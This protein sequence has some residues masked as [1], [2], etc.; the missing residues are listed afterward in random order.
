MADATTTSNKIRN[1][2]Y[3]GLNCCIE[4]LEEL[5]TAWS[6]ST[7]NLIALAN[8]AHAWGLDIAAFKKPRY[9]DVIRHRQDCCFKGTTSKDAFEE[10]TFSAVA[11]DGFTTWASDPMLDF[12]D[13]TG[14]GFPIN[15]TNDF[16]GG[17]SS[18]PVD[19]MQPGIDWT[20]PFG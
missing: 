12:G 11:V 6:W 14:L 20:L 5:E 2:A 15:G 10:S 13:G 19:T 18:W 3:R 4:S 1:D 9:Q 16:N 8:V 7:R 17:F